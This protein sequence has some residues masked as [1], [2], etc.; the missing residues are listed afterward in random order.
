MKNFSKVLIAY[1]LIALL[2]SCTAGGSEREDR[3]GEIDSLF[4]SGDYGRAQEQIVAFLEDYPD[5]SQGHLLYGW[6]SLE[7]NHFDKARMEFLKA[8]QLDE[9]SDNAY[10]GLGVLARKEG[11]YARAAEYYQQ[12]IEIYPRNPEAYSSLL[13]IEIACGRYQEAL[14]LAQKS[15]DYDFTDPTLYANASIAYHLVGEVEERDRLYDL[16]VENGYL[17]GSALQEIYA[18]ESVIP[19]QDCGD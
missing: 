4:F 2:A 6:I 5:S 18:G 1:V 11:D 16:A 8:I 15:L 17:N 12:A 19:V 3:L 9:T 14:E 10:V 13:V 7:T